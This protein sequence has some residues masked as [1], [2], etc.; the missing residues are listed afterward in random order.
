MLVY[1]QSKGELRKFNA[2][3]L[4]KGWTLIGLGYAGNGDGKN[5]PA[6][7]TRRAIGPIPRGFWRI[8]SPYDSR[9]TGPLTIPVYKLDANPGDDMDA[10]TGRSAFRIHGDS[11][12]RPGTASKGCIIV[13]RSV[14]DAIIAS[15]DEILWVVE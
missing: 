11:I 7:E 6:S 8:G 10:V 2:E 5:D 9:N 3:V 4:A 13:N 15:R 14:R 12:A 1:S